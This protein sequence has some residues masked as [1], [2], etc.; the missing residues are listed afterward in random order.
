MIQY[1]IAY[2]I[3]LNPLLPKFV[4]SLN[5]SL[6]FSLHAYASLSLKLLTLVLTR[7]QKIL[8]DFRPPDTYPRTF[9][10]SDWR[11]NT[12]SSVGEF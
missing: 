11:V 3:F 2:I 5:T 6:N 4:P 10:C 12:A 7:L 8:I 9:G 1:A